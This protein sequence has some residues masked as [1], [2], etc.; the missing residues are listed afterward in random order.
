LTD[1]LRR[2]A[3]PRTVPALIEVASLPTPKALPATGT[4]MPLTADGPD[5][6]PAIGYGQ[7]LALTSTGGWDAVRV[8]AAE[9]L[10]RV[11]DRRAEPVLRAVLADRREEWTLRAGVAWALADL[12]GERAVPALVAALGQEEDDVRNAAAEALARIGRPAV[13]TLLDLLRT[14]LARGG[15]DLD[16]G[17]WAAWALGKIADRRAAPLLAVADQ[18]S[19]YIGTS[20]VFCSARSGV[21]Y[22][23][24][25]G[26]R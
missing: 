20:C 7:R 1:L 12:A 24:L 10:A 25:R 11:G 19:H 16:E 21:A 23:Q 13:P 26:P 6:R 4:L 14:R 9:A 15:R 8:R 2:I 18:R 5:V 3:D 17:D 22:A